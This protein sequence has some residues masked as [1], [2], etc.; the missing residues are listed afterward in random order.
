LHVLLGSQTLGGAYS[1]ARSTI[2]QMAVRIALQ[3]SDADA[4][5]ILN[6]DNLAARLLSRP[7]EAIYNDAN[8]L[9]EGNDLFQIVWLPEEKREHYLE[10]MRSRANGHLPPPL[11]FEGNIPSVLPN[12]QPLLKRLNSP[13]WSDPPRA[14]QAW[15]G[16]AV[17]IKDPTSAVFRPQSGNNLLMIGQSED[18]ALNLF[19]SSL[20][21]LA[22]QYAPDSAKLF[23]LDGTNEDDPN[24]GTLSQIVKSL[25]H[26]IQMVQRHE[27]GNTL[28]TV[29]EEVSKRQ[30]GESSDRSPRFI[31]I[32]GLHRYRDLRK[33]DDYGFGRRGEKQASPGELFAS[34]LREG[35]PMGVH[36]LMW[37]DTLTNLNRAIDRQGMRECSLRVLFQMSANDSSTL[38]DTPVASRLG[39]NRALY[40]TEESSQ[41][42]KFRPYGLPSAEFLTQVQQQFENRRSPVIG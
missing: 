10:T 37:V 21:S 20:I 12:N 35:P 1:L 25:P 31:L 27:L 23:V 15:L 32:H 8:G 3:C 34:L 33:E 5:L 9:L 2:D 6:K 41:H 30:K 38:I 13:N 11:V 39:R 17:A 7:G 14:G 22:V 4:Q 36:F 18:V 42:E 26:P 16:E 24:W 29:N 19:A 40:V 28:A